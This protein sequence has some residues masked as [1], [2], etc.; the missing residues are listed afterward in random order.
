METRWSLIL[1]RWLSPLTTLASRLR[2]SSLPRETTTS[3][4][5]VSNK[6]IKID[7]KTFEVRYLSFLWTQNSLFLL[8]VD[9][10]IDNDD[11]GVTVINIVDAHGLIE[12]NF[13][14]KDFMALIKAYLKK[15]VEKL[16][17]NG[18]EERVKGFQ[19]GA[20]GMIKFI[21]EKFDEMQFFMGQSG[22][23]E[24]GICMAYTMDGEMDPTFMYFVDGMREEK[25]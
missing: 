8:L 12:T 25:F 4:L 1:T 18:N 15:T 9:D 2:E 20:T 19:T 13:S 14:K 16:K 21:I 22:D 3:R 11:K 5:Q 7:A 23:P 10:E 6:K 17:E 24:C